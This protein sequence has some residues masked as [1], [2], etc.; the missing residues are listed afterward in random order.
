MQDKYGLNF[1]DLN[2][3]YFDCKCSDFNHVFRFVLDESSG[4]VWLEVHL[5]VCEPW[6]K[7]LWTAVRYFFGKTKAYGHYDTTLLREDDFVKF[8]ALLD[9][10]IQAKR[11][12]V[13]AN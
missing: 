2:R 7:R 10:A 3:V 12:Q 6:Y 11:R 9:L 1:T 4:D 8:H 13:K 5:N